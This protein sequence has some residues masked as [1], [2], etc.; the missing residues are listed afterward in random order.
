M[1]EP[2]TDGRDH[3]GLQVPWK[4]TILMVRIST[5]G[6]QISNEVIEV[7][8]QYLKLALEDSPHG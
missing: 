4:D 1:N 7:V 5:P 3:L 6:Q 8:Q 2:F